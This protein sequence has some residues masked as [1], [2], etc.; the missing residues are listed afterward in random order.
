MTSE[1]QDAAH[2]CPRGD[3]DDSRTSE[4]RQNEKARRFSS[5]HPFLYVWVMVIVPQ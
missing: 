4:V 5:D 3:L 2:C 1:H